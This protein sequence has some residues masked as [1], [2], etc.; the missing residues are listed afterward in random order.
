M[1]VFLTCLLSVFFFISIFYK[2]ALPS[3]A[4]RANIKRIEITNLNPIQAVIFWQ[5]D[6]K[7]IS[8]LVYGEEKNNLNKIVFDDRDIKEEKKPYFNH[9]VTLKNLTPGKKYYFTIIL[10]N[11]KIIKPD[12]DYFTFK[13]PETIS[14]LTKLNPI[15]GKVLNENLLP[16]SEGI[17][18]LTINNKNFFS[19][20]SLLKNSGEWLI[21]LNSFYSRDDFLEQ[22]LN[23][24]EKAIIE[25][26]SEENKKTTIT[27]T[28]RQLIKE[29]KTVII[30][31]NYDYLEE[32]NN[33]LSV[34]EKF[35]NIKKIEIIYPKENALIP[36][37]QPLIKGTAIPFSLVSLSI[38]SKNKKYSININVDKDGNWNYLIP[39]N[40]DLGKHTIILLT[41]D[42]NKKDF[43][44]IRNFTII[45]NDAFEGKV[46]GTAS[47][48]S[49][50]SP[51]YKL[52]PSPTIIV[53]NSPTSLPRLTKIPVSGNISIL[54]MFFSLF[55][56]LIGFVILSFR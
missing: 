55:F 51:T 49:K 47:G 5:T 2:K 1:I 9:Y 31:K 19:L 17:V 20:S 15:N 13:T 27:G 37:R 16:L 45:G 29:S 34:N 48:E 53:Y 30:G 56:I 7:K 25:I 52:K 36:G 6:E 33:I 18:L 39:E 12:G 24:E 38:F 14:N 32:E 21:P 22:N 35:N 46:L 26:F 40:L 28:L 54:S 44:L 10:D 42:E 50:I 41:K 23:E 43:K 3:K 4:S 11:Q 8:W